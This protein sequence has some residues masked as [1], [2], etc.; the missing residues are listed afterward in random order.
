MRRDG[1]DAAE[2]EAR[3]AAQMPL[4]EKRRRATF[5]IENDADLESLDRQVEALWEELRGC[6]REG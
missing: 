1:L 2:A 6:Q 4:E 5:V 3:I